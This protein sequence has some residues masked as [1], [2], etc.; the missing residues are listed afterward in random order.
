M[1]NYGLDPLF[2]SPLG[3]D[4]EVG[5]TD[6]DLTLSTGSPAIDAGTNLIL[7]KDGADLNDNG[8][9]DELIPFDHAGVSRVLDDTDTTDKGE[10]F[11]GGGA[12]VDQ[13][14]FEYE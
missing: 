1:G 6:D 5:T 7:P 10:A 12:I 9:F 13:G 14:A 11:A 8:T 4:A 3:A 2:S